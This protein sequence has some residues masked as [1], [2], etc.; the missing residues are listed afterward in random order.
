MCI[1]KVSSQ[2]LFHELEES[3]HRAYSRAINVPASFPLIFMI[4]TRPIR[5]VVQVHTLIGYRQNKWSIKD[6]FYFYFVNIGITRPGVA[7]E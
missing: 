6:R 7:R 2:I 1:D 4:P 5:V 3:I